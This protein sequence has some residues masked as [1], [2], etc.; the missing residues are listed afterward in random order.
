MKMQS[1]CKILHDGHSEYIDDLWWWDF[2][3]FIYLFF[4]SVEVVKVKYYKLPSAHHCLISVFKE[5][6]ASYHESPI[7]LGEHTGRDDYLEGS[8]SRRQKGSAPGEQV[9]GLL[10]F[11]SSQLLTNAQVKGALPFATILRLWLI[12]L[13]AIIEKDCV[14]LE[15]VGMATRVGK[16]SGWC[17]FPSVVLSPGELA[18]QRTS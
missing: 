11:S 12:P 17:Y 14:L 10:L 3:L 7:R 18:S 16:R 1:F 8:W 2:L 5:E 6:V 4:W 13:P 9:P 15:L